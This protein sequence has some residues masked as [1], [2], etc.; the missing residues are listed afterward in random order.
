MSGSSRLSN[1]SRICTIVTLLPNRRNICPNSRPTY[2]PPNTTRCSG[3]LSSSMIEILSRKGTRSKPSSGGRD[4]RTPTLMKSRSALTAR[5]LPS[6]KRTCKDFGPVKLASPKINSRFAVFS[7]ALLDSI[8]ETVHHVTL[9]L[10]NP[11][12][13]HADRTGA[14]SIIG[15]TARQVR[16]P[17][18]GHHRLG[19]SA[20]FVHAGSPNMLALDQSRAQPSLCQ[21]PAQRC[22]TL[23]RPDD[24]RVILLR[25]ISRDVHGTHSNGNVVRMMIGEC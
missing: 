8:A 11:F 23:T 21:C 24:D 6:F 1:C 2:P 19:W 10:S 20:T 16:H 9:A 25:R 7:R 14:N 5:A 4:A 15:S 3:T 18:A 22:A 17:S 13:V 12:H